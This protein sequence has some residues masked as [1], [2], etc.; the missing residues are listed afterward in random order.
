VSCAL[1]VRVP[2]ENNEDLQVPLSV[3]WSRFE[4]ACFAK[5][6]TRLTFF[7]A[8][9]RRW[10]SSAPSIRVIARVAQNLTPG[11]GRRRFAWDSRSLRPARRYC[12]GAPRTDVGITCNRNVDA[13]TMLQ[14]CPDN[15]RSWAGPPKSSSQDLMRTKASADLPINQHFRSQQRASPQ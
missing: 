12:S 4:E 14:S 2:A 6:F 8:P 11:G 7:S 5:A 1:R 3:S 13:Q 10:G 15:G 9:R